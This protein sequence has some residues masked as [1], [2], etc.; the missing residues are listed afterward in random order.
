MI[1]LLLSLIFFQTID[2]NIVEKKSLE[3]REILKKESVYFRRAGKSTKSRIV[4]RDILLAVGSPS[5]DKINTVRLSVEV[6]KSTHGGSFKFKTVT[7]GYNIER[8]S[9]LGITRLIFK[10]TDKN[11]NEELIVWDSRHLHLENQRTSPRDLYYFLYSDYFLQEDVTREGSDFLSGSIKEVQKEI[12]QKKIMSRAF[13][14]KSICDIYGDIGKYL[15]ALGASEQIDDGEFSKSSDYSISKFLVHV[16]RNKEQ[17]FY[18]SVSADGARGLMQFMNKKRNMTYKWVKDSYPEAEFI[19]DF[20]KGT[21]D[22]KNSLMAGWLLFDLNISKLSNDAR[23]L[24]LI[25]PKLGGFLGAAAHNAGWKRGAKR[26]F[27]EIITGKI[28]VETKDF[29]KSKVPKETRGFLNKF[30]YVWD[31]VQERR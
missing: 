2:A 7:P 19:S 24:V 17:A 23:S 28:T 12:C 9:G 30:S 10:V 27:A 18:Y 25:S 1:P 5:A 16:G 21:A 31:T 11:T 4:S 6:P 29:G 20:E 8:T 13:P 14:G 26:L 3:A 22:F 15:Y